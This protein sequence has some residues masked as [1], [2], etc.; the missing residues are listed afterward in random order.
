MSWPFPDAF[1][2][3]G[4]ERTGTVGTGATSTAAA[5]LR[6]A[7]N[8]AA[9]TGNFRLG[10]FGFVDFLH[11]CLHEFVKG[12]ARGNESFA[13]PWNAPIRFAPGKPHACMFVND[14]R[15]KLFAPSLCCTGSIRS[16]QP[17]MPT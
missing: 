1:K 5:V 9:A 7:G 12:W 4:S 15:E 17:S 13:V 16:G 2:D 10:Q 11:A 8:L 3:A 14:A 6:T